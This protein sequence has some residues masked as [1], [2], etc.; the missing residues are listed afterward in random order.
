MSDA[1]ATPPTFS[2]ST[3]WNSAQHASGEAIVDEI[4]K[5]GFDAV[6]LGYQLDEEQAAGVL[7]RVRQ[8][9]VAV[10]SV[11]AFCPAP[12]HVSGGHPEL[13][14]AASLD[15]DDRVMAVLLAGKTLELAQET[16]AR[17]VILHA[18]RVQPGPWWRRGP[19]SE[20]LVRLASEVGFEDPR[21]RKQTARA[22]QARARRAGRH[23]EA[24]RRSLDRLVPRFEKAGAALCLENLPS[25]EAVPSEDEIE[26]L[27]ADYPARALAYW[28][29]LG[30]G[31]VRQHLGWIP[32]HAAAAARLL[33][34]TRGVHIHDVRGIADDHQAPG[35]GVLDFTR[36]A[37]YG[38]AAVIRVFEPL[39][40]TPPAAIA[41][42]LAHVRQTWGG[43]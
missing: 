14:L 27:V 41:A 12:A 38:T 18:G 17:A 16:G 40:G 13:Y 42:G 29:D 23:L 34:I 8:G 3:N 10:S 32:D 35:E 22:L 39:P 11:H 43:G 25:W 36:F 6:E 9:G 37:F 33:P 30:H 24:L 20:R 2:L 7:R 21:F 15:E 1:Q 4:L 26:R 19:G 28:H 5:L 31:Q